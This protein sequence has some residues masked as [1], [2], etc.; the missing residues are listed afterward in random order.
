MMMMDSCRKITEQASDYVDRNMTFGQRMKMRM[1]L[2]M[3]HHCRN[4]IGQF[5]I[6][7]GAIKGLGSK[8]KISD[9]DVEKQLKCI[10]KEKKDQ[11]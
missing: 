10:L 7:I 4:F 2:L 8:N 6:T 11:E 1:H 5:Q 3:C 9:Q